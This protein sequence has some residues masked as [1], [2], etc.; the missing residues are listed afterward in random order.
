MTPSP[1]RALRFPLKLP[2]RYRVAGRSDWCDGTTENISRSG[3]L[4]RASELLDVN[5]PIEVDVSFPA[6]TRPELVR[7]VV[8][9]ANVVR[10]LS[11]TGQDNRLGIAAAFTSYS[12]TRGSG[13]GQKID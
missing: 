6:K 2:V 9:Q 3:V 13:P 5:T 8:C 10:T 1:K 12:I 7:H 11:P 4:F